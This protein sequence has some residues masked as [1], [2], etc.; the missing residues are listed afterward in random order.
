MSRCLAS[1]NKRRCAAIWPSR[2]RRRA[3]FS[4]ERR[5]QRSALR[6]RQK[7]RKRGAWTQSASEKGI[8]GRVG[9]QVRPLKWTCSSMVQ[10]PLASREG[11]SSEERATIDAYAWAAWGASC[12]IS[13]VVCVRIAR[14]ICAPKKVERLG[15]LETWVCR[16]ARCLVP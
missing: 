7:G 9:S 8:K 12:C 4:E 13:C 1:T 11:G 5:A 3:T 2:E 16:G 14:Q 6:D 15:V 10:R